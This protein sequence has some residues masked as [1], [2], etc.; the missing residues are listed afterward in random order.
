[1]SSAR[2]VGM[3]FLTQP[4]ISQSGCDV[5]F[6]AQ[7]GLEL[8]NQNITKYTKK[9]VLASP[10]YFDFQ[11]QYQTQQWTTLNGQ[12]DMGPDQATCFYNYANQQASY[13]PYQA[14]GNMLTQGVL[15]SLK[16]LK[17]YLP[18]SF[19]ARTMAYRIAYNQQNADGNMACKTSVGVA[20]LNDT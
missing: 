19:A 7:D 6:T 10:N 16:S 3:N 13:A 20:I 12:F 15:S 1:M 18:I 5:S 14:Y 2:Q 4:E 9:S 8:F 11:E 17:T